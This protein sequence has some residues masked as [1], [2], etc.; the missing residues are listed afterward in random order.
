MAYDASKRRSSAIA[1]QQAIRKS[2]TKKKNKESKEVKEA[3]QER[4]KRR[5]SIVKIQAQ[6]RKVNSKKELERL[7]SEKRQS[8]NAGKKSRGSTRGSAKESSPENRRRGSAIAIQQA[9]K[10]SSGR[11]TTKKGSASGKVAV[12][13]DGGSPKSASPKSAKKYILET[14]FKTKNHIDPNHLPPRGPCIS[15]LTTRHDGPNQI[16]NNLWLGNR[17]DAM[18]YDLLKRLKIT[19]VLNATAQLDN[20]H[21][22]KGILYMKINIKDKES[23]DLSPYFAQTTRFIADAINANKNVLVHCV[24]GASRSASFIMCYLMSNVG[25]S[26][27]LLDAFRW[28]KA[29]RNCVMP[30]KMFIL[31]LAQQE[32]EFHD[33]GSSVDKVS[34]KCFCSYEM[35]ELKRKQ[36]KRHIEGGLKVRHRA[37]VIM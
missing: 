31:Q 14:G 3:Q 17:E 36:V 2:Q 10:K 13:G 29:R 26:L 7:K 33:G 19:V 30:N 32:L 34:E 15:K 28:C 16:L 25:H 27:C 20:F 11:K 1:I 24:A 22:D 18:D 37:C 8:T 35:N 4:A 6:L 21:D 9:W 12:G 5:S 23:T